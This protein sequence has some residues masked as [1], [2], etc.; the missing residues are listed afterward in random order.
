MRAECLHGTDADLGLLERMGIDDQILQ[1]A[2]LLQTRGRKVLD[3]I[4]H[5]SP[6]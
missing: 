3:R 6:G 1:R 4:L 2:D 5:E